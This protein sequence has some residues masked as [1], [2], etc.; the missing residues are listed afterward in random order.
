MIPLLLRETLDSIKVDHK[1]ILPVSQTLQYAVEARGGYALIKAFEEGKTLEDLDIQGEKSQ[2]GIVVPME[3]VKELI[4]VP[5]PIITVDMIEKHK[6]MHN[7]V[8]FFSADQINVFCEG[9]SVYM[10]PLVKTVIMHSLSGK[11][12]AEYL[13]THH[14]FRA[15]AKEYSREFLKRVKTA[16]M[17]EQ[18][19]DLRDLALQLVHH[20]AQEMKVSF[21]EE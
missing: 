1:D 7:G 19:S 18:P 16:L 12:L 17:L 9:E 20:Y 21:F 5:L 3:V 11:E 8:A 4:Y 6:D 14:G 10:E 2:H 13:Q 15:V